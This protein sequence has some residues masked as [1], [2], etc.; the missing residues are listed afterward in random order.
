MF[1]VAGHEYVALD[2]INGGVFCLTVKS[3]GNFRFGRSNDWRTSTIREYLNRD[4]VETLKA[5]GLPEGVLLPLIIDLKDT[6]GGREYGYDTCEVG[7]LTLEQ[8]IKYAEH[9]PL[10]EDAAWWLA[11]PWGTPASRSPYTSSSSFAWLVYTSGGLSGYGASATD[12][13]RPALVL[14][15]SLLV[16]QTVKQREGVKV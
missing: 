14:P 11:T 4:H 1:T 6:S 9:I 15:S 8:Y 12:G 5:N 7:L 13:V 16:S 2:Q 3:I 10:V